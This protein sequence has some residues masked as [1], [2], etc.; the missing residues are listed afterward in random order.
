[1]QVVMGDS[2][3]FAGRRRRPGRLGVCVSVGRT[4][5]IVH[6]QASVFF[7]EGTRV[8]RRPR[9]ALGTYLSV[10]EGMWGVPPAEGRKA[11]Q[12]PSRDPA[13]ERRQL[14]GGRLYR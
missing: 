3:V 11:L 4:G 9:R 14:R 7:G 1:M 8:R 10:R 6:A 12:R 5:D 13:Q 2:R